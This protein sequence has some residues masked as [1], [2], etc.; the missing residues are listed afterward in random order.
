MCLFMMVQNH[1]ALMIFTA[2]QFRC[3]SVLREDR[4]AHLERRTP[5]SKSRRPRTCSLPEA[6]RTYHL[7][8]SSEIITVE[9]LPF[10]KA[11]LFLD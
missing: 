4:R 7:C 9:L 5:P 11:I 1:M 8:G 3:W 2:L 10:G 6:L